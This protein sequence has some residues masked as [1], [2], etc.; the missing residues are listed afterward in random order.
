MR[1]IDAIK[2][3]TPFRIAVACR[4]PAADLRRML[5]NGTVDP[6]GAGQ[7]PALL[8]TATAT[9]ELWPGQPKP[10]PALAELIHA[11]M[12]KWSPTTHRLHHAKFREA[13]H[14]VLLVAGRLRTT[15]GARRPR[16]APG[17]DVAGGAR[18]APPTGLAMNDQQ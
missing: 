11:A 8:D 3:W 5:R 15:A 7:L 16:G 18:P 12:A 13:V 4:C 17:T 10:V 6:A 1:F 9:D 2:G 14:T